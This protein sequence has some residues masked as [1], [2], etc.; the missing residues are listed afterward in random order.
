VSK[1][2]QL[3]LPINGLVTQHWDTIKDY[4][5]PAID[6]AVE[7]GS[8]S[9][10]DDNSHK[11]EKKRSNKSNLTSDLDLIPICTAANYMSLTGFDLDTQGAT[12]LPPREYTLKVRETGS[13]GLRLDILEKA[14]AVSYKGRDLGQRDKGGDGPGL[15]T[16]SAIHGDD[17]QSTTTED[18]MLDM[19]YKI[20]HVE[21]G[22]HI[23][24]AAR[25]IHLDT[26]TVIGST[27]ISIN[28]VKVGSPSP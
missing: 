3:L 18:T 9:N 12:L 25:N 4:V 16:G 10:S 26:N 13:L 20:A 21:P 27:I 2:A 28:G 14:V 1:S 8:V 23:S 15:G 17:G 7:G 6:T 22:G 11:E 5:L 24:T 19:Q